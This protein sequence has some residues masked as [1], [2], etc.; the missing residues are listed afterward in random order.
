MTRCNHRIKRHRRRVVRHA[1]RATLAAAMSLFNFVRRPI[2]EIQPW[3]EPG[4]HTLSWFGLSD[5]WYW[6][7]L[8]GQELFRGR[9]PEQPGEPPYVGYQVVRLWEDVLD[10]APAVLAPVPPDLAGLLRAPEAFLAHAERLRAD[11]AA[12]GATEDDVDDGLAFW[13]ARYLGTAHLVAAPEL[14][15][16]SDGETVHALWRSQPAGAELW[17]AVAGT[18]AMPV[19]QFI[20]ELRAFDRAFLTE[21]GERVTDVVRGGGLP[22]VAI[23]LEHLVAE[24]RDRSTWMENALSRTP[25][26]DWP[27]ARSLLGGLAAG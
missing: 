17:Q 26:E 6:L 20:D 14:W 11:P 12:H 13:H 18:T 23:D 19:G 8:A 25:L 27:A 21:M 1:W 2:A 15:L 9:E 10:I 16:W 7:E 22:G 24:Q 4:R 5:G 3:G